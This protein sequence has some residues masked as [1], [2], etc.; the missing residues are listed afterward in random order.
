VYEFDRGAFR[1]APELSEIGPKRT[2]RHRYGLELLRIETEKPNRAL[3]KVD[4]AK[5]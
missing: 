4:L 3:H 5:R 1:C 2:G